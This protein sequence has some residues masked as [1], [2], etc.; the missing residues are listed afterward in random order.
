MNTIIKMNMIDVSKSFRPS[1][2]LDSALVGTKVTG[3]IDTTTSS[4]H[5]DNG[6]RIS[7]VKVLGFQGGKHP[8]NFAVDAAEFWDSGGR[9]SSPVHPIGPPRALSGFSPS[10]DDDDDD[11]D[12]QPNELPDSSPEPR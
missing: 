5:F 2:K 1:L 8:V 7:R 6:F 11:D 10:Y 12:G 9:E 3:S 4:S